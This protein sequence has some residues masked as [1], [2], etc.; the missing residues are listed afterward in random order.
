VTSD[1]RMHD[2]LRRMVAAAGRGPLADVAARI[3]DRSLPRRRGSLTILTYHRVDDPSARLDLMPN[4]ISATPADFEA[5]VRLVA[6]D[7]DPVSLGDVLEALDDPQRMPRRAVLVTF[8]DG[9]R[10]FAVNAWPILRRASVPATLFVA[11]AFTDDPRRRFWWDRLWAAVAQAEP[12]TVQTA[13]GQLPVGQEAA[14]T[15]VPRIRSWLKDLDH[16]Q[17]L[18]EVDRLVERLAVGAPEDARAPEPTVLRWDELRELAVDGVTLA[19]HTRDHPIL[20]RVA[21]DRAVEEI[22][23]SQADLERETGSLAPVPPVLAYP[24]GSAGDSAVEAARRAGMRLAMT[25][26]RGGNDLR[27]TDPLRF[28]RINV[29]GRSSVPLIRAQL[30]WAGSLDVVR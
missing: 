2:R 25:T 9:Y 20:D 23:A 1:G 21:L 6:R 3:V 27:R 17:V 14:T 30:A 4:L 7:F 29:G 5:Q 11:T 24:S 13:V 22:T 19:P 28:R 15:S 16:D 10:D 12:A 18:Q 8:D 26:K